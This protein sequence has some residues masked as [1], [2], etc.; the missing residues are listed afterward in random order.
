[1]LILLFNCGQYFLS[2]FILFPSESVKVFHFCM[3]IFFMALR[4]YIHS[5]LSKN[6]FFHFC[7]CVSLCG[8]RLKGK[9]FGKYIYTYLNSVSIS[10]I[11][12]IVRL[13]NANYHLNNSISCI[14]VSSSSPN[15]LF[16]FIKFL[17]F[18]ILM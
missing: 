12:S 14:I 10:G 3:F 7:C 17:H 6:K 18:N 5:D 8:A 4:F 2:L 16:L 11:Y 9:D 1:M 15:N 13:V